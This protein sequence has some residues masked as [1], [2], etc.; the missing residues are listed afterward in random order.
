MAAATRRNVF[1]VTNHPSPHLAGLFAYLEERGE[2]HLLLQWDTDPERDWPP[3]PVKA[4]SI[5]YE[6]SRVSTLRFFARALTTRGSTIIF[7][8]MQGKGLKVLLLLVF[9]YF[10]FVN[11]LNAILMMEFNREYSFHPWQRRAM[12]LFLR[13]MGRRFMPL[14]LSLSNRGAFPLPM[15]PSVFHYTPDL[16]SFLKIPIRD[17][18]ERSVA[19]VGSLIPRKQVLEVSEHFAQRLPTHELHLVGDGPLRVQLAEIAQ[20]HTNIHLV[21]PI[22]YE[23]RHEIF[24]KFGVLLVFSVHDGFG[25]AVFEAMAAGC[26]VIANQYTGSAYCIEHGRNG[27]L[28]SSLDAFS[29]AVDSIGQMSPDRRNAVG[30]AARATIV[31]LYELR[32]FQSVVGF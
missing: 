15:V 31:R 30:Q 23:A 32:G 9:R 5:A 22:S 6:S 29:E 17:R 8:N 12:A 4:R 1:L 27:Y 21:P 28:V 19:M 25:C 7:S 3:Y 10:G 13:G 11:R 26:I 14:G 24:L 20:E 2:L 18:F 16:Q